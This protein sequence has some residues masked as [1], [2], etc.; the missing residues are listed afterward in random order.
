V[1]GCGI[2]EIIMS[3]LHPAKCVQTDN[4][5]LKK[6]RT[7]MSI[8]NARAF[9]EKVKG[10][11]SLQQ[12]IG[13][14]AKEKPAEMEAIIVKVAE[15]NGF[16]FTLKE[17]RDFMEELTKNAPNSGELSDAELEAVAGGLDK[18]DWIGGS[19]MTLGIGCIASAISTDCKK[20]NLYG[21]S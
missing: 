2:N 5:K 9:Y 7:K 6:G 8:E 20:E 17:M 19:L 18:L 4:S 14:L 1:L 10:D 21:G 15:G 16:Q 11:Q 12:K 13:Q 3:R